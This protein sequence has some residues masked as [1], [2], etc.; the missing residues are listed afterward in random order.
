MQ[1]MSPPFIKQTYKEESQKKNGEKRR[2]FSAK[3]KRASR[4]LDVVGAKKKKYRDR[5]TRQTS[6]QAKYKYVHFTNSSM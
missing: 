2:N 1:N 6:M 4:N 3:I 5:E